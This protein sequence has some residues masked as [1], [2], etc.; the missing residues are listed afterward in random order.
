MGAELPP[1]KE[2]ILKTPP[3]PYKF[4]LNKMADSIPRIPDKQDG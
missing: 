3:P 4:F 2:K 1:W